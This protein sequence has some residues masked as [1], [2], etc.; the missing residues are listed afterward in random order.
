MTRTRRR[1]GPFA[2][3][4]TFGQILKWAD[5]FHL[6][7]RAWPNLHSGRIPGAL[8]ETWRKVDNALRLGLRGLPGKSSL[9]LFLTER[10]GARTQASLPRLNTAQI[11]VW[12]DSHHASTGKWPKDWSGFIPEAPGECWHAV[13]RALRAGVRGLQGG[14][15]LARLLAE[16]RGVRNHKALP[17]LTEEMILEWADDYHARTGDWPI[18]WSGNIPQATDG[19]TWLAVETALRYGRRGLPGGSSLAQLL[20]ARRGVRNAKR[21]PPLREAQILAWARSYYRRHGRWPTHD[22]GPVYEAPDVT[23]KAIATSLR[24]G[25]RGLPGGVSLSRFLEDHG[26]GR[27]SRKPVAV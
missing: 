16:Q 15:S 13:D 4:L 25:W 19:T 2:P 10:R 26:P 18:R 14:S 1:R 24:D 23:W 27:V 21:L 11:L 20:A 5:E 9:A 3:R 22:A 8:G 6:R 12:A 7:S 17:H